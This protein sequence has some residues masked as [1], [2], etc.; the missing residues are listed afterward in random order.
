VEARL[1]RRIQRYGWDAAALVYEDGWYNN[2]APAQEL[3]LEKADLRPG[4]EVFEAAAGSGLVT[5]RAATE[6]AP[7]GFVTATDISGEMIKL[8]AAKAADL[9]VE[10]VNF[11]RMDVEAIDCDANRFDRALCALGLMYVPDPVNALREMH[12]ILRPG[13]R[14]SVAVWGDRNNCGWAEIF[15]IVDARVKSEVCPMF[16]G[17]GMEGALTRD[18]EAAGFVDIQEYRINSTLRYSDDNTMLEAMIDGG[19]VALAAKRFSEDVR[20]QVDD[21]FITSV[22]AYRTEAG[23]YAIPGE[24]VIATGIAQKPDI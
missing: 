8:A 15:P 5:F 2:L 18:V 4:L 23:G 11:V 17:I 9:G 12:R 24:F 13:G 1:Q 6:V 10:N 20:R 19:A 16:F 22:A 7:G 3:M 21:E 14:I